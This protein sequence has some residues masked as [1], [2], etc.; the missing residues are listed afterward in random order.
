MLGQQFL[1][2]FD[3]LIDIRGKRLEFGKQE[4]RGSRTLFR[5]RD[6]RNAVSTSLGYLVLD[7]GAPNVMLFG[8]KSGVGDRRDLLT[9]TGSQ[10]VGMVARGL[11]IEGQVVW[12]GDAVA[13]PGE[14]ESGI[15]GLMPLSLFKT[16]Y[17]CNSQGYI[18]FE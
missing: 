3:Y 8:V 4:P 17:V 6:G 14:G 10:P 13:I 2:G 1:S 18:E 12:R 7:S 9:L 15:A 5:S 11:T 16:V